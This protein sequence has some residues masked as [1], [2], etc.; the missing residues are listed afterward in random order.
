MHDIKGDTCPLPRGA[1]DR[2]VSV[3]KLNEGLFYCHLFSQDLI[4]ATLLIAKF[5]ALLYDSLISKLSCQER[6]KQELLG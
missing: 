5:N 6:K 3:H 4:F 1:S 2:I